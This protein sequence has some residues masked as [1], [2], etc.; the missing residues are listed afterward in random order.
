MKTKSII[1]ITLLALLALATSCDTPEAGEPGSI[2][3]TTLLAG[4]I[5]NVTITNATTTRTKPGTSTLPTRATGTDGYDGPVKKAFVTDDIIAITYYNGKKLMTTTSEALEPSSPASEITWLTST[6]L[7]INADTAR[8]VATYAADV[9]PVTNNG[10]TTYPDKLQAVAT[11][12]DG[13]NYTTDPATITLTFRHTQTLLVMGTVSEAG[14]GAPLEINTSQPVD[15]EITEAGGDTKTIRTGEAPEPGSPAELAVIAPPGATINTVT[16]TLAN[17]MQ[18]TAHPVGA[19]LV[20]ALESGTRHP[21]NITVSGQTAT[22]TPPAE[23]EITPWGTEKTAYPVPEGYDRAIYTEDDLVAFHD[24]VNKGESLDAKVIQMADITLTGKWNVPI[25]FGT[26]FTGTYNGNGYTISGLKMNRTNVNVALFDIVD[27]ATLTNIHL[28]DVELTGVNAAALAISAK[29]NSI[30]SLCSATGNVTAAISA[31]GLVL[32]FL[33]GTLLRS[34]ATCT[35]IANG[36]TSSYAGGLVGRNGGTILG[37]MAGGSV[38]G[39]ALNKGGLVGHNYKGA[40][41]HSYTTTPNIDLVGFNEGGTIASC[42]D[43]ATVYDAAG[44]P[45]DISATNTP[46]DLVRDDKHE[47]AGKEY[48]GTDIWTS[49]DYPTLRYTYEG[50]PKQ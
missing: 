10:I 19:G 13:I 49:G 15:I 46:G 30:I 17:G 29:N 11:A 48:Y 1:P 7:Y 24:A 14:T 18:F 9:E 28:R 2:D 37:C 36:S 50:I 3:T 31:G 16:F 27:G 38:A 6:D 47:V 25:A 45:S 20:S 22:I 5:T 23:G 4:T 34:R 40:I 21:I 8:I 33:D 12:G 41:Y 43:T 42:Y 26:K 39:T 44:T 32:D 35:I